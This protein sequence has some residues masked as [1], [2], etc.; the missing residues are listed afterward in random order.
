[1][2]RKKIPENETTDETILRQTKESISN[3]SNRSEKTSWNRKMDNMV[4]LITRLQP[5]EEKIIELQNEKIPVFDE[6]QKLRL[7]MVNE[8][9]HPFEY[10]VIS[11][12]HALCKFCSKKV[13]L[14]NGSN[15][16]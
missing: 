3:N 1:M 4:K 2:A 16:T 14:P 6:L 15:E 7:T 8:C 9:I 10:L 11:E 5:L 13:S 12:D